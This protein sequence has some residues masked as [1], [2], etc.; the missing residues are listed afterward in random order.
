MS[1][2]TKFERMLNSTL[3]RCTVLSVA[4][5]HCVPLNASIFE[6]LEEYFLDVELAYP[7][8]DLDLDENTRRTLSVQILHEMK[9]M[10]TASAGMLTERG[11]DNY[12]DAHLGDALDN[13]L[14]DLWLQLA[15]CNADV[16]NTRF[17]TLREEANSD[18]VRSEMVQQLVHLLRELETDFD[19]FVASLQTPMWRRS[20]WASG[21]NPDAVIQELTDIYRS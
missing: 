4:I 6:I 21:V 16:F 5:A 11:L 1:A 17:E 13:E 10:V 15:R 9:V 20:V 19:R 2:Q 12:L 8:P 7:L 18:D 14:N 3:D